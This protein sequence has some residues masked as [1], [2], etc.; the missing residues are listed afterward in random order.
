MNT[1]DFKMIAC[2]TWK[3]IRYLSESIFV[4]FLATFSY[5]QN[6]LGDLVGSALNIE[7]DV[8]TWLELGLRLIGWV[9]LLVGGAGW[10]YRKW[11]PK[12]K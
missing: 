4:F 9:I 2:Y 6:I 5:I 12:N 7:G 1:E 3:A 8:P 11:F 10:A